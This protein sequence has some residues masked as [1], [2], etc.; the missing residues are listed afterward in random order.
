MPGP[1]RGKG[2]KWQRIAA[3]V[4]GAVGVAA[5]RR[6]HQRGVVGRRLRLGVLRKQTRGGQRDNAKGGGRRFMA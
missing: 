3:L 4:G 1:R 6:R 5:V 2:E